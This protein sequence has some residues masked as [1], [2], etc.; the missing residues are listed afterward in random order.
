MFICATSGQLFSG[1]KPTAK[2]GAGKEAVF[3]RQGAQSG[4]LIKSPWTV[5]GVSY[6][7]AQGLGQECS[8]RTGF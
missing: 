3:W 5:H 2:W 8:Y 7:Q 4:V 1:E 6:P